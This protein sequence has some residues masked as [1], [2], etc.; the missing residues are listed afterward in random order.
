MGAVLFFFFLPVEC[1]CVVATLLGRRQR[2]ILRQ[3]VGLVRIGSDDS[4]WATANSID[5]SVWDRRPSVAP[6][7]LQSLS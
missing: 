3:N 6:L 5:G 2:P 1:F 4:V 7:H